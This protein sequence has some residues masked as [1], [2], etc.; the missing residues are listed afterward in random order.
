MRRPVSC[1]EAVAGDGGAFRVEW[2]DWSVVNREAARGVVEIEDD[3]AAR[4]GDDAHGLVEDFAAVAVG[5]EDVAGGAAGVDADEDRMR[6]DGARGGSRGCG[7]AVEAIIWSAPDGDCA[8]D[9]SGGTQ[10]E[11]VAVGAEVAADEGDVAF[12]TLDLALVGDHAELAVAGLDAGFAGADDVA[13]VAET[14]TNE[15]GDG[16]HA[17]A[18]L[19]A[20]RDEVRNAGH[21]AVVAHDFADDAGGGEAGETSEIDGGLGLAGADEDAAAASAEREDVAGTDEVGGGGAWVDGDADGVGAIGGGDAGGDAL[22]SFD[23]FGEGG[24]EAG[25]VLLVM[26]GRRRWSA[27]SSVRVRQMRPRP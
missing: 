21:F 5:G 26:G 7:G 18:V 19:A 24:A 6:A 16:D 8:G 27:R 20:K 23:R 3:A 15:L 2:G 25:G 9:G 11:G 22:A 14:V 1:G 4:F 12:A 13:L 17:E 10:M